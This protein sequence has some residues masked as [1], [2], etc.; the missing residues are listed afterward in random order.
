M[1]YRYFQI[2]QKSIKVSVSVSGLSP[3]LNLCIEDGNPK[4]LVVFSHFPC[5]DFSLEHASALLICL[6]QV[7]AL[8]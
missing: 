3:T 8:S 6:L 7:F 2:R 1:Y 4:K 5:F